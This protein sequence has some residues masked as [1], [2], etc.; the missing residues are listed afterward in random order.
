[1]MVH[2]VAIVEET[3]K[4]FPYFQSCSFD[5][6]FHSKTNQEELSKILDHVTLPR[7]GKLSVA[8]K[9]IENDEM[10][11][12]ARKKHSAVESSINAL[13][14]HGLDRCPDRGIE[15]FK[16]YTAL[17]VVARNIQIVGAKL[18]QKELKKLQRKS[19][20]LKLAA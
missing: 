5:K 10:F 11:K 7:K 1:M 3:Q 18:Q 9:E 16:R 14:N 15:G 20:K 13:E 4:R 6:G 12:E 2:P 19:K 8:S 17:A